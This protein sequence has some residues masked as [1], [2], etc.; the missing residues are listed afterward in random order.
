LVGARAVLIQGPSGSGKSRLAL[1]L[2]HAASQNL[3]PFAR[4]VADD[5]AH[6]EAAH[7]RLLVR[8]AEALAGL[9]EVRGLGL[10]RLPCE[11]VAVV[12]LVVEIGAQDTERLPA[13]NGTQTVLAGIRLP[14]LAIAAGEDPLP[15]ILGFLSSQADSA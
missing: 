5:R 10:R 8:P 13:R 11:H 15:S 9:I 12:G 2:L 6:I 3:I 7:G 1:N 14:R 4:L